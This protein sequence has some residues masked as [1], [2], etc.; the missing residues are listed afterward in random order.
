MPTTSELIV[1][2]LLEWG[3]DTYFGLA[4]DGINGFFEALRTRSDRIRFIHVRHEEEA[5][6]AAVGHAK[7]SGRPAACVTTSGPGAIHLLNGLYDA[8]IEGAPLIAITGTT[9]HDMVGT[10]FLQ[11]L[12][13]DYVFND[14]CAFNQRVNGPAHAVNAADLAVRAALAHRAA[15]HLAIAIDVQSWELDEGMISD[16]NVPG[17]TS[18]TRDP[19]VTVPPRAE[20]ARA[21]AALRGRTKV[22]IIAGAGARGAGEELERVAERLAAPITKPALG[23]DCVP[24]DSPYTTGGIA[25]AGTRPSQEALETCDGLLIVGSSS[26]YYDFW[27]APGQAVGVQIDDREERIGLRYP[28]QVGLVGDARATLAELFE[29]LEPNSDRSFLERAQEGMRDWWA[30]MDRQGTDPSTP[31]KPQ[32][33]THHLQRLLADDAIVCG[34]AGTTTIWQG[35]MRLRRGQSF[36]FSGTNCSMAASI[37]YAMGAQVAFPDR[38]VVAFTGDGALSMLMG[39]LATLAQ[40]R[41]P[42]TVVVINNSS[43]NL[44]LW[45]QMAFL[46]NPEFAC[47][48]SPVDFAK[49]AEGCG[50]RATRVTDP[51]DCEAALRDALAHDGPALVDCV[52]D[53][54][55]SPLGETLKPAQAKHLAQALADGSPGAVPKARRLLQEE[56]V[57]VSPG[58]QA[59]RSELAQ[60]LQDGE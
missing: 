11:D 10:H 32:V 17:H 1:D 45:E 47:D 3:I 12:N 21:A 55:E 54:E 51:G 4:G 6:L 38:Q 35:R 30:L 58:L 59:A 49:V 24:D 56:R 60:L 39:D 53:P 20:L 2:R 57:A 26:N 48:L 50:L 22:A 33:V 42:I 9:Y 14:A 13:Q 18:V 8:R 46:G 23:K 27:P 7:L 36:T 34:D 37:P 19:R 16:K 31:M 43:I 52:V 29:Q 41:L 5:A 15:S 25:F 40:H 28:V 44:I